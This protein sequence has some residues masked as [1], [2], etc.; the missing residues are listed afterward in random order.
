LIEQT[1]TDLL[2]FVRAKVKFPLAEP[3]QPLSVTSEV[4]V[5]RLLPPM[6]CKRLDA[7]GDE[8][9]TGVV[10][11]QYYDAV[12]GSMFCVL[13]VLQK[14]LYGPKTSWGLYSIELAACEPLSEPPTFDFARLYYGARMLKRAKKEV[15]EQAEVYLRVDDNDSNFLEPC[16]ACI[17]LEVNKWAT[18]KSNQAQRMMVWEKHIDR[19]EDLRI[20]AEKARVEEKVW[21]QSIKGR[22]VT[23]AQTIMLE[24]CRQLIRARPQMRVDRTEGTRKLVLHF[25]LHDGTRREE[26][27]HKELLYIYGNL[28]IELLFDEKKEMHLDIKS[29]CAEEFITVVVDLFYV[30]AFNCTLRQVISLMPILDDL[31]CDT[32]QRQSLEIVDRLCTLDH[33]SALLQTRK[34]VTRNDFGELFDKSLSKILQPK[35]RQCSA[36]KRNLR[37]SIYE[38]LEKLKLL[39]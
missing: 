9:F 39:K 12:Y 17:L 20:A 7:R 19:L 8:L 11:F 33:L 37:R 29:R 4:V 27:L 1:M 16:Y 30:G 21:A 3:T 22:T 28:D 35:I 26:R 6:I 38:E 18:L 5:E 24:T 25:E 13:D 32:L 10:L 36:L 23:A 2:R 31:G 34:F 14:G 15:I